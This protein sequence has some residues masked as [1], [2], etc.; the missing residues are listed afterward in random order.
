M[1]FEFLTSTFIEF[2]AILGQNRDN[3]AVCDNSIGRITGLL[4][5]CLV[6]VDIVMCNTIDF[7]SEVERL[8]TH[9]MVND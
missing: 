1:N 2:R 7:P 8:H 4:L 5:S 9:R 6:H 3:T